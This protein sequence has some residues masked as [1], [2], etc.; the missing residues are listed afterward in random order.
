[1]DER[2]DGEDVDEGAAELLEIVRMMVAYTDQASA[3]GAVPA[4]L[5]VTS[6]EPES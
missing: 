3:S 4:L 6:P 2:D 5:T 1:M